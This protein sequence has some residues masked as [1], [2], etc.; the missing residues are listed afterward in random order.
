MEVKGGVKDLLN[1][2]IEY[3]QFLKLTNESGGQR[4]TEQLIRSYRP[5]IMVN[6][7]VSVK[8]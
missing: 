3:K 7:G 5:G 8:F 4:E 1:A 6:L 2:K